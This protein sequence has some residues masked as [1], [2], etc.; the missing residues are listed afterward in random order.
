M[1][2]LG[3]DYITLLTPILGGVNDK[4]TAVDLTEALIASAASSHIFFV[5][6]S[7]P[8]SRFILL[9]LKTA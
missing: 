3:H 2:L 5:I 9:H 1:G 8:K 7:R 4:K 6:F